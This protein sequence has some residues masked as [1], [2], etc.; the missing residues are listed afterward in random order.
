MKMLHQSLLIFTSLP[1]FA[2][3]KSYISTECEG[4]LTDDSLK[5]SALFNLTSYAKNAYLGAL[6]ISRQVGIF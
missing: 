1:V 3:T 4:D 6:Q 5:K 2:H